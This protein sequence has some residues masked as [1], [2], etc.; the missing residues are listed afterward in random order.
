M[1]ETLPYMTHL[2]D[3]VARNN[4]IKVLLHNKQASIVT[5]V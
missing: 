5:V 3:A 2:I 4:E 1:V